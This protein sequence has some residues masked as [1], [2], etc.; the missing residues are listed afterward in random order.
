MISSKTDP[1]TGTK[2][3]LHCYHTDNK[4]QLQ[5]G[6]LGSTGLSSASWIAKNLII[7]LTHS[8]IE[9]NQEN[10]RCI[11]EEILATHQEPSCEKCK[12]A[13]AGDN[14]AAKDQALKCWKC[15]KLYHKRCTDRQAHKGANWRKDPWYCLHCTHGLQPSST[16]SL[17]LAHAAPH[18][19]SAVAPIP[20]TSSERP[21]PISLTHTPSLSA[22]DVSET[23]IGPASMPIS[24]SPANQTPMAVSSSSVPT[25]NFPSN[26]TRH[27]ASNVNNKDPEKEFL[28]TALDS[29][30]STIIQQETEI[31]RLKESQDICNTRIMQLQAQV[32]FSA[33]E[34]S[35]RNL[36]EPADPSSAS[37]SAKNCVNSN[38]ATIL[39]KLEETLQ[40]L[41]SQTNNNITIYNS[42]PPNTMDNYRKDDSTQT[43]VLVLDCGKASKGQADIRPCE[44]CN[45]QPK[46]LSEIEKHIETDHASNTNF[47][48]ESCKEGFTSDRELE[49]HT[50][51]K[52]NKDLQTTSVRCDF[53]DETFQSP[54]Q[55]LEHTD[56]M[57]V[58]DYLACTFCKYR[59][60]TKSL[61]NYHTESN[62]GS[63]N[64]TQPSVPVLTTAQPL[65]NT[66]H[67]VPDPSRVQSMENQT[68]NL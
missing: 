3:V 63:T 26:I 19:S 27:R 55:L 23:G 41:R 67:T 1:S 61:L 34:L 54:S 52:H 48:C 20:S 21:A 31:K 14:L 16:Q 13:I 15:G 57:H 62:H 2:A 33:E 47:Y 37:C 56:S 12:K 25:V 29:C 36:K 53:C 64:I 4:I 38:M 51:C 68:K 10:I 5:G 11:N 66:I 59:C 40:T 7:P 50:N 6:P 17:P 18:A 30:R 35:S 60:R 49:G 44:T 39:T 22:A 58:S 46:S 9:K 28:Q 42:S 8:H 43:D 24:S 65:H 32:G 45:S